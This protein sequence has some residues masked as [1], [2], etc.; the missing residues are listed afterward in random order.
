MEENSFELK[1]PTHAP[2]PLK[3][4]EARAGQGRG[5]T[6]CQGSASY[7]CPRCSVNYCG[8]KCYQSEAHR[9]CSE[10]FYKECVERELHGQGLGEESKKKMQDILQRVHRKEEEEEEEDVMDSD[11][12]EEAEELEKRLEGVD[13]E[14]TSKVWSSLTKE[15]KRQFQEMLNSGELVGLMP[16]YKP[17]WKQ[18][19]ELKK[20]V[21]VGEEELDET[22]RKSCPTVCEKIPNLRNVLKN[23]SPFIK[24]GLLN[25]LYGYTYAVKF[26]NGDYNADNGAH[27]VEIIQLLAST[28]DGQNFELADTAVEA[29]ASEVNN[30]QWLT[31]SLEH[32]RNVKK[33]VYE[34]VKGPTGEDN[35]YILAALSDMKTV[36]E[37]AVKNLKKGSKRNK[38]IEVL[39]AAADADEEELPAWLSEKQQQPELELGR[40]R[41]HLKKIEFYLSW[42][43][44][45]YQV[46]KEL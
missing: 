35:F 41:K 42:S 45:F 8:L 28:L 30:H 32:S 39:K 37:A 34:L 26:F 10:G 23:P 20:I 21:E 2:A 4:K 27:F 7:T 11:D 13:L 15:E 25:L 9:E 12:E 38:N 33:D 29:A 31:V 14:D 43:Q 16:E 44:D 22:L 19:V 3:G 5:C 36:F 6:Y 24:Y 17:W 18:R 46:F 1:F 40:V